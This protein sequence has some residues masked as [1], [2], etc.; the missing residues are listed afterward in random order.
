MYNTYIFSKIS[1]PPY[2]Q[3][4]PDLELNEM[5]AHETKLYRY[6]PD[7]YRKKYIIPKIALRC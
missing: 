7:V 1:Y 5:Q 6:G 3:P 2:L 4:S